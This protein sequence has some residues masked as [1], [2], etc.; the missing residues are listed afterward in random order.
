MKEKQFKV[1]INT[2][3][4]GFSLM[5]TVALLIVDKSNNPLIYML[6]LPLSMAIV[7]LWSAFA[8]LDWR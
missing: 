3:K 5:I 2:M 8:N 7:W 6:Y 1:L 4:M